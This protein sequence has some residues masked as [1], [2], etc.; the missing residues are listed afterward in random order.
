MLENSIDKK[1]KASLS[2]SVEKDRASRKDTREIPDEPSP[3]VSP[4]KKKVGKASRL[5]DESTER[6]APPEKPQPRKQPAEYGVGARRVSPALIKSRAEE[7]LGEMEEGKGLHVVGSRPT[8]ASNPSRLELKQKGVPSMQNLRKRQTNEQSPRKEDQ[9]H[10]LPE[11]S[12]NMLLHH[13]Q[14]AGRMLERSKVPRYH[15]NLQRVS[16][17]YSNANASS[18]S[19]LRMN[20]RANPHE[21]QRKKDRSV[22]LPE[23]HKSP[24][25]N[26]RSKGGRLSNMEEDPLTI[27]SLRYHY[28]AFAGK[29]KSVEKS[30]PKSISLVAKVYE[31]PHLDINKRSGEDLRKVL[32]RKKLEEAY[33]D[34]SV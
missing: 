25:L 16:D 2:R 19:P 5:A 9:V 28:K 6:T 8:L 24:L 13:Q 1:S 10:G 12:L 17:V 11:S 29:K 20:R 30:L 3:S 27:E 21:G 34:F 15:Q 32:S 23:L 18:I 26:G 4:E 14:L 22:L 33:G 7:E 31:T